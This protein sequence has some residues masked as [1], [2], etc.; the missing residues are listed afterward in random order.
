[1]YY[2]RDPILATDLEMDPRE[3]RSDG[4]NNPA[5][6]VGNS[7]SPEPRQYYGILWRQLL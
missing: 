1:M 5:P 2:T 7:Y 4:D 3:Q 6:F